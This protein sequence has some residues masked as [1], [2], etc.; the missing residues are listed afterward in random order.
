MEQ[1]Q[2]SYAKF[3]ATSVQE[4]W[5]RYVAYE[6]SAISKNYPAAPVNLNVSN[7]GVNQLGCGPVV[8]VFN[9]GTCSYV[10]GAPQFIMIWPCINT[11]KYGTVVSMLR[12]PEFSDS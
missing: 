12:T 5:D 11:G 2:A 8:Q 6:Y 1:I 10:E 4:K 3:E 7:V 9:H